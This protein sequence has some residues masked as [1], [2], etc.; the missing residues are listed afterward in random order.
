M[1][2]HVGNGSSC[3]KMFC[4]FR[5]VWDVLDVSGR[6]EGCEYAAGGRFKIRGVR[7]SVVKVL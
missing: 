3:W 1:C 5:K 4:V 6:E 7:G 2:C